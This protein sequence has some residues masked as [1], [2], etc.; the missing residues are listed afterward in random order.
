MDHAACTFQG[1]PHQPQGDPA[2]G[3]VP[4]LIS[5]IANE[6]D[7]LILNLKPGDEITATLVEDNIGISKEFN[8]FELQNALG[9]RNIFKANQIVQYFERT[10]RTIRW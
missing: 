1:L 2:N 9:K 4:V 8:V 3:R 10:P 7:K 5:R 6:I